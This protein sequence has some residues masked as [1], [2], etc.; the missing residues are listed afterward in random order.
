MERFETLYPLTSREKE[1]KEIVQFISRSQSCQL[2]S[3]PGAGRSTVLRLLAY[4]KELVANHLGKDQEKYL[5]IYV[6]FAE[7]PGFELI[8]L[9]KA[10]FVAMLA[11]VRE[12]GSEK[13][14]WTEAGKEIYAIFKEALSLND[15]FVFSQSLKK[16]VEKLSQKAIIPVFLFD[17][18]SEFA[19][20]APVEFF[21]SLRSLRI[22]SGGKLAAVF[23]THRAL[24]DLLPPNHWGEFAEFFIGNHI[25]L[26]MHDKI[27]TDFRIGVLEKEYGRQQDA[28]IKREIERLTGGHGRLVKL[29]TQIFLNGEKAKSKAK[30]SDILLDNS[31]IKGSLLEIW[32]GLTREERDSLR[33]EKQAVLLAKLGLP[34]PLL[35]EFIKRNLPETLISKTIRLNDTTKEIYFG[36]EQLSDFTAQEFRLLSFFI[37]NPNRVCDR[38]EVI[39]AVW[40]DSKTQI[41]VSDE[42]LD[43][44]IYRVRKKIEDEADNPKH[45]L[46][47]KGR[48]FR[49]IP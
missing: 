32:E 13:E 49:F 21:N 7:L 26:D 40:T 48:G 29:S 23:S 22:A 34:F 14:P 44:M 39:N 2:I 25:Y 31:L 12:I 45:L 6:N 1:I 27:A 43:Q 42:A 28:K 46:T 16:A 15:T 35:T 19:E 24:E 5:F 4:H 3:V 18:F 47:V 9:N 10:L 33:E 36:N 11:G 8:D 41:G 20:K 38:D 30:V 37:Q 17:R